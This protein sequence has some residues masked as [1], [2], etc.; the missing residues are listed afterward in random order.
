VEI[1]GGTAVACSSESRMSRQWFSEHVPVA[2]DT[3]ATIEELLEL[4][5]SDRSM[6]RG[7]IMRTTA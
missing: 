3:H 5:L 4:V 2:M 1:S 7:Y 6:Q